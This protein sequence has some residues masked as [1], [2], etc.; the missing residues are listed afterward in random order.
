MKN[1][2]ILYCFTLLFFSQF[3]FSQYQTGLVPRQSPDRGAYEKIGYTEVNVK[4]GSPAVKLRKLWGNLVPFDKVWRAGANNATTIEFSTD[5]TIDGKIL[6]KG[7]YS[8]FVIPKAG[9]KWV[10]IFNKVHK[11]WGAYKYDKKEDAIRI[12]VSPF[13]R[14]DFIENLTYS[15]HQTD[16]QNGYITL[17]WGVREFE[18]HFKTNYFAAFKKEVE[19]RAEKQ[20]E[21]IKWVVYLQGAEHLE[22]KEHDLSLAMEWINKAEKVMDEKTE[23]NEGF[24]PKAYIQG[25]VLWVKAKLL[26]R[27]FNFDEAVLYIEKLKNMEDPQFYTKENEDE[28]IDS[29]LYYWELGEPK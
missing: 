25:H 17:A 5:V 10:A 2:N 4:Y 13:E 6:E 27:N 3:A 14:F 7:K 28:E 19:E 18:V 29:S 26:A 9:N 16:L 1:L 8:F 12:Y 11:Q 22:Q 21:N 24:Y 20:P 15:I 23:W